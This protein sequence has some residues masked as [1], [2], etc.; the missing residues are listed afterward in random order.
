M[1]SG[2]AFA[3]IKLR[4]DADTIV[5]PTQRVHIIAPDLTGTYTGVRI[6]GVALETVGTAQTVTVLIFSFIAFNL[7]H[8]V[9]YEDVVELLE[10]L[11]LFRRKATKIKVRNLL[12]SL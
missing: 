5:S 1:K 7:C 6:N 9:A 12:A 11:L 4:I 3:A 8:T 10:C 2:L